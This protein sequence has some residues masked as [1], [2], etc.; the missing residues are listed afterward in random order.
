MKIIRK[1]IVDMN[2]RQ[3]MKDFVEQISKKFGSFHLI[4]NNLVQ[5]GLKTST[6]KYW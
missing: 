5:T 1:S 4:K 3:D 2:E 6:P